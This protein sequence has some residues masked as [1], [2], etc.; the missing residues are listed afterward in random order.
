MRFGMLLLMLTMSFTG[1]TGDSQ[2]EYD[3]QCGNQMCKVWEHGR[4]VCELKQYGVAVWDRTCIDRVE[5]SEEAHVEAPYRN[6]RAV[7]E[8]ASLYGA[9]VTFKK[10]CQYRIEIRN[11]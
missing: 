5:L 7:K 9:I 6:E 1:T 10:N 8:E 11:R 4:F 2:C 3:E